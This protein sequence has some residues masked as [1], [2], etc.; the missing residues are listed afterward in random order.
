MMDGFGMG[1]GMFFG[2]LW[3]VLVIGGAVALAVYLARRGKG[4]GPQGRHAREIL[5]DRFARGEI[6]SQEYEAK[7]RALDR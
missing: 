5:D 1:G 4:T 6:D 7:R 3:W 2:A